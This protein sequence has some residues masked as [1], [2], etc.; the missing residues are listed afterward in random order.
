MIMGFDTI[1]K[2][3]AELWLHYAGQFSVRQRLVYLNHAAVAPLCRPVAEARRWLAADAMENGSLHYG[4]WLETY[5]GLRVAA[6]RLVGADWSEI[7]D[8]QNTSEGI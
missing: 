3:Q 7:A 8:A 5:E 4:H 2:S 1:A 6:A